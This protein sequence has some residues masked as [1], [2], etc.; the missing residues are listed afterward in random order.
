MEQF[1]PAQ[2]AGTALVNVLTGKYNPAGRLPNTWPASL[3]QVGLVWREGGREDG[4]G[5]EG[6]GREGGRRKGGSKEK[7]EGMREGGR[8]MFLVST[9]FHRSLPSLTTQW[10][11][12]HI[13]ISKA[14]LSTHLDMDC[15]SRYLTVY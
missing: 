2:T 12:G 6:E 13:A 1:F 14:Y 11:E 7:R 8:E 3:E 4:G 15:K 10:W 5:G 9:L